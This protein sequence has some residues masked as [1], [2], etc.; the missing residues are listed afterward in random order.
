VRSAPPAAAPEGLSKQ[1]AM[2]FLLSKVAC[3]CSPIP[4]VSGLVLLLA[5]PL[6]PQRRWSG[7]LSSSG[8]ALLLD[9][10][11]PCR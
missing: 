8:I 2:D 3:R 7:W 1:P 10:S 4:S 11:L 6:G 9:F 5:G